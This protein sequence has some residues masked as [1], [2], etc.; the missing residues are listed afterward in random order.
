MPD[1]VDRLLLVTDVNKRTTV[2]PEYI[3]FA[4]QESAF[5]AMVKKKVDT[6]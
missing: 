3:E 6:E 4:T 2:D 1:T 5:L